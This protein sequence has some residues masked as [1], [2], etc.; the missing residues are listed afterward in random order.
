MVGSSSQIEH[1]AVILL[2]RSHNACGPAF[3]A[4]FRHVSYVEVDRCQSVVQTL[5]CR[6]DH[7]RSAGA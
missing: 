5:A 1:V 6:L 2:Y 3:P 7:A 4:T